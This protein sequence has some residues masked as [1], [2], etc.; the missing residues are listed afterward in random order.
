MQQASALVNDPAEPLRQ[1]FALFWGL[2][3]YLLR[4]TTNALMLATNSTKSKQISPSNAK[5][6][7]C[8]TGHAK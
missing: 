1:F 4:T 2:E 8:S 3:I 7:L 6:I 5:K